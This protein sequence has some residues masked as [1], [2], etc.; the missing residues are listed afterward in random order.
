MIDL[1]DIIIKDRILNLKGKKDS[2]DYSLFNCFVILSMN[3]IYGEKN[4]VKIQ[5]QDRKNLHV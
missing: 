4:G 3:K 1:F 5:I 2:F